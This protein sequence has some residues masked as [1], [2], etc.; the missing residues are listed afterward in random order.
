MSV[1]SQNNRLMAI[2]IDDKLKEVDDRLLFLAS[3]IDDRLKTIALEMDE[4][5]A[6]LPE[7]PA[8]EE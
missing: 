1:Y 3:L 4:A 8:L 7:L 5:I 6:N 2:N